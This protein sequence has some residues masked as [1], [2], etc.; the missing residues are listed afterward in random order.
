MCQKFLEII[1]YHICKKYKKSQHK[2]DLIESWVTKF[3]TKMKCFN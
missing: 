2:N 1:L 3:Y